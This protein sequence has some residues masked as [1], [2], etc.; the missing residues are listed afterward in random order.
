MPFRAIRAGQSGSGV[1]TELVML[2]DNDLDVGDVTVRIDYS[3]I[4]YKDGLAVT[5]A[6]PIV[7]RF[8][9]IPDIDL[10]AVLLS[11]HGRG[12]SR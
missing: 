5:N 7:Q 10:A 3:T 4:N 12:R 11:G 1:T 9:L 2:D 6:S 8:P